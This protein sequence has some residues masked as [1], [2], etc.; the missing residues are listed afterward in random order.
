[1]RVVDGRAAERWG[2][3]DTYEL[4]VQLGAISAPQPA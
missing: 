3:L 1:L 4:M 2:G